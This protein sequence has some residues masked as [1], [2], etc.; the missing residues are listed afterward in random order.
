[1]RIIVKTKEKIRL[2]RFLEW[3]LYFASYSLVFFLVSF[4]FETC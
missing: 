3:L 4:G 2:N 1:M